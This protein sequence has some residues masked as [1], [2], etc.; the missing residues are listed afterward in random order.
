MTKLLEQAL[1]EVEKLPEADQDAAAGALVDYLAHRRD[2]RLT[3]AQIAEIRR[4]LAF[5]R[6]LVSHENARVRIRRGP[7]ATFLEWSSEADE[8]AYRGL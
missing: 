4:R 6:T 1:R 7:F 2:V 3:D 8:R 5:E